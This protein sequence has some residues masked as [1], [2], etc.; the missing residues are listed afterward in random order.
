MQTFPALILCSDQNFRGGARGT[1]QSRSPSPKPPDRSPS[2]E[3][4]S[5]P[6]SALKACK[7]KEAEA[8]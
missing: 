4:A 3:R 1:E 7:D 8:C 2:T 5:S 6:V